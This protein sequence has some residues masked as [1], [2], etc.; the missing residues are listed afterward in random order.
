M[1]INKIAKF[2]YLFWENWEIKVSSTEG[3]TCFSAIVLKH[4]RFQKEEV[5]F[6]QERESFLK[7]SLFSPFKIHG[8]FVP[9]S[10]KEMYKQHL[11]SKTNE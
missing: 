2:H 5:L 10:F 7:V 8:Y 3:V 9:E 11:P 4:T 6:N 1:K